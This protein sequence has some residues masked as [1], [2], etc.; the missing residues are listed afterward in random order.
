METEKGQQTAFAQL[1]RKMQVAYRDIGMSPSSRLE[2]SADELY[3][4][5]KD[6]ESSSYRFLQRLRCFSKELPSR[7]RLVLLYS[8][9]DSSYH[10]EFWHLQYFSSREYR[11]TLRSLESKIKEAFPA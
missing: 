9:L 2:A 7:E 4:R 3:I 11:A 5:K 10:Y 6:R 8:I 1:K